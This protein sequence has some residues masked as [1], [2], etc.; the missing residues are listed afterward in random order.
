MRRTAAFLKR[1]A[2]EMVRDP[3]IYVFC[4]G[5]PVVMIVLFQAI[6]ACTNG[7]TPMF[8]APA[9]VPGII[10]FSFT[11]VMLSV[12][13]L[14]S[15]DRRTAFLIRLYTSP[16]RT[17]E[18][19]LGYALP[20]LA[21]G[22]MQEIV[23]LLFSYIVALIVGGTYFS[24]GAAVLLMLEMLPMLV[25]STALGLLF[26]SV[27]SEKSAP[28]VTSVL[29]SV[30]GILGGAWMPLDTMGG[31]ETFCRCMPFYPAVY[32]G[33]IVTGAVHTPTGAVPPAVYSFDRVASLGII[34]IAVWLVASVVLSVLAFKRN[35][36]SDKK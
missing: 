21:V 8:E 12:S 6:N 28:A 11:F 27:L 3:L 7:N 31:F 5:F 4:L 25:L 34:P 10:M 29:I 32:I 24:F 17:V 9:L 20:F 33:R 26:G 23:C 22:I 35:M 1:N 18:Y 15:R 19:L 36:V 16:M 30:A 2:L 13:L 14:V